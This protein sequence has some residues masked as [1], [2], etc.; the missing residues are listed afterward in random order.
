[1]AQ[2]EGGAGGGA[3][4]ADPAADPS[5]ARSLAGS[6]P[7]GLGPPSSLT[8]SSQPDRGAALALHPLARASASE[9]ALSE[10]GA[11]E[12]GGSALS[13]GEVVAPMR[14]LAAELVAALESEEEVGCV[15]VG[16]WVGVCLWV[17][18]WVGGW[19]FVGGWVGGRE[20]GGACMHA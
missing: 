9:P 14:Q 13:A 7:G 3:P 15:F 18:G 11:S 19:V 4:P 10:G 17:G 2:E 8:A 6:A 12:R 1:M 16:G 5:S 20:G